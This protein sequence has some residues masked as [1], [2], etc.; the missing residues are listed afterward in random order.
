MTDKQEFTNE[1][2]NYVEGKIKIEDCGHWW[3]WAHR[4]KGCIEA[5]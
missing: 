3:H 5:Q 1:E 4:V 2:V